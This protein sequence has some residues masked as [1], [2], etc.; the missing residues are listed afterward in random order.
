MEFDG[1]VI[2]EELASRGLLDEFFEAV[3][4]DDLVRV[5]KILESVDVDEETI[6]IVLEKIDSL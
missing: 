2:L 3:D 6:R 5:Y 4:N 1:T